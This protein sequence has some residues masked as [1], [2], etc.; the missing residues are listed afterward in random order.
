MK[1]VSDHMLVLFQF[2]RMYLKNSCNEVAASS[3]SV[4]FVTPPLRKN[5][6]NAEFFSSVFSRIWT[7]YED[8]WS[9]SPYSVQILEN[10]DQK[11]SVFEHLS[12]SEYLAVDK[13][14]NSVYPH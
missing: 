9:K 2:A 4:L 3:N 12:R 14:L 6:S 5:C 1:H 10:M 7:E 11:N 8:L 13:S